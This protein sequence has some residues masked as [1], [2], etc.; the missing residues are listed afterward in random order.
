MTS[1]DPG[2]RS[3]PASPFEAE[4]DAVGRDRAG[5]SAASDQ[6]PS[7]IV[8][9]VS[10]FHCLYQDALEFH[11]QSKQ[12]M[13]R[14]EG[15]SSRL[16]RASLLLYVAS[17]EGLIHQ[18][19]AEL[20]R[21]ELAGLVANPARPLPLADAWTLLP[22]I[23]GHGSGDPSAPPWP[24]FAELLA[25]RAT[26]AYPGAASERRA[27]Y[28]ASRNGADFEPLQPHQVDREIGLRPESLHYPRT[29]FPRDPYALRP[30]HLDTARAI[31]DASIA[32]LDRRLEGA[33]TRGN[34]HRREL[35][36]IVPPASGR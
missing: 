30:R 14:S 28:R 33:L 22:A 34:R 27:Y 17:A 24:Q 31:L 25:L 4:V 21:P 2:P 13:A 9:E 26:W 10:P 12:M 7:V 5:R 32:A 18:A 16:A 8:T 3:L 23:L 36:S 11:S 20:A 19:A 6:A 35:T 1:G 29:G 15:A